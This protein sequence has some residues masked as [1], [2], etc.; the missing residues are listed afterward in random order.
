MRRAVLSCRCG[1]STG[2]LATWGYAVVR[3]RLQPSK[4]VSWPVKLDSIWRP[5][6]AVIFAAS[7]I[8]LIQPATIA[9]TMI[10][11]VIP[12]SKMGVKRSTLKYRRTLEPA[13][14]ALLYLYGRV[15]NEA[16]TWKNIWGVRVCRSILERWHA[17]FAPV[18]LSISRCILG[19]TKRADTSFCTFTFLLREG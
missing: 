11:V 4:V 16:K 19:Q 3:V 6:S 15:R 10:A 13:A 8:R 14:R 2:Q 5:R 17:R 12:E 7:S 18:Y 9:R 1:H